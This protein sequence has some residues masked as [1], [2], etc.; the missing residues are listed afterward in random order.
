MELYENGVS[1]CRI[2]SKKEDDNVTQEYQEHGILSAR[3]VFTM[4]LTPGARFHFSPNA[5]YAIV[6]F[7]QPNRAIEIIDSQ[8]ETVKYRHV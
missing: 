6:E 1:I 5:Q 8:H 3:P 7:G 4:K 2:L